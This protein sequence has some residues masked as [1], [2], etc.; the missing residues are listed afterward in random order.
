MLRMKALHRMEA[1]T[2]QALCAMV[3]AFQQRVELA[4]QLANS[5]EGEGILAQMAG[6]GFLI[7]VS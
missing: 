7:Q 3:A 2:T 4:T 1:S 5:S 6:V